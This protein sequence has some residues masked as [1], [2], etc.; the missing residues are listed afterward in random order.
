RNTL[1]NIERTD[2]DR[3]DVAKGALVVQRGSWAYV[4]DNVINGPAG[5]GPLGGEPG[6]SDIDAR[7]EHAAFRGNQFNGYQFSIGDGSE[8]VLMSDN[9]FKTDSASAIHINGYN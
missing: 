4:S 7:F 2:E 9:L 1:T 8:H 6:L 5:M 3:Y